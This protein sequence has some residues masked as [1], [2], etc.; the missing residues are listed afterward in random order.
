[1]KDQ[2]KNALTFTP[3]T[4]HLVRS[5]VAVVIA[6]IVMLVAYQ[7]IIN[8]KFYGQQQLKNQAIRDC[9]DTT[10]RIYT[11]SNSAHVKF[12]KTCIEDKGYSSNIEL[13]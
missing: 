9:G 13:K 12:Y 10:S 1:M 2:H 8:L 4:G 7:A 3:E 6:I 11:A 5:G